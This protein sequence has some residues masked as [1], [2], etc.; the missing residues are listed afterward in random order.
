[1]H[2][3]QQVLVSLSKH[4]LGLSLK[5]FDHKEF[6]VKFPPFLLVE[7]AIAFLNRYPPLRKCRRGFSYTQDKY[8]E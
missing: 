2:P 3:G 5:A 8:R 6:L 1:M 4:L 7:K